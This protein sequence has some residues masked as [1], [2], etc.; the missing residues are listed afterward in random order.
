[1]SW[2]E[3]EAAKTENRM[4]MRQLYEQGMQVSP[5]EST[6]TAKTRRS[7]EGDSGECQ[8]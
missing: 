7:D 3:N 4:I 2:A 5:N 6:H 8:L 1:M